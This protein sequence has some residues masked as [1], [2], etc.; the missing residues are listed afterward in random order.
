MNKKLGYFFKRFIFNHAF[1]AHP[2][3]GMKVSKMVDNWS[4]ST[5]SSF[6][7]VLILFNKA[8]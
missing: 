1:M 7:S 6:P 4:S 8:W 3:S 2:H 5:F